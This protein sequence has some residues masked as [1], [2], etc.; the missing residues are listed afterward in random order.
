MPRTVERPP[1]PPL[2]ASRHL[3][4]GFL[5]LNDAAPLI[6][7][8]EH[9]FFAKY[10]LPVQLSREVGWATVRD[11]IIYGELQAAHALAAMLVSTKLG[12]GCQPCDC[13]TACV[14]SSQGN[15]ITLSERLWSE[16]V[17][18]A[19]TLRDAVVRSRHDRPLVFGVVFHHSTHH[20][21]LCDWLRAAGINPRRDVRIVVVPPPQVF[22]NL[23][24]GTIDGYC[25]GEPWNSVAV[26]EKA[27]WCAAL[28][29]DL[30][31]GHPEK[32]LMVRHDF[33]A[34][35]AEEHLALVA[36][37]TEAAALC[38]QPEFRPELVRLL[39]R[40]EYLNIPERT[41]AAGLVGPFDSGH[42][43]HADAAGF[44][45]F[46]HGGASDPVPAKIEWV[47]EGFRRNALIPPDMTI[48]RHL[49]R[50]VFRTDLFHQ[51][52]QR[53]RIS[54]YHDH[55]IVSA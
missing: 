14:L 9:G 41:V 6:V 50:D 29:R 39:A 21:H 16:G 48:P 40:R 19:A 55:A 44:V 33:A 32:V 31:P 35:R 30:A 49:S 27:G 26:R 2:P 28:S 18:D 45:S 43:S 53:H 8:Q 51:A 54:P 3:R 34:H 4:I 15:A 11:K 42:G 12:L 37:I 46:S 47:I 20:L 1:P 24:A 10:G 52:A 17:R 22:R 25:V 38:D 5:A 13:L 7:A 36:A 23:V